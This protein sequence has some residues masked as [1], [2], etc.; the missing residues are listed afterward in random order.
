MLPSVSHLLDDPRGW[1]ERPLEDLVDH[2][3]GHH[4]A[5]RH[6]VP[7]LVAAARA[8]DG[9]D[10]TVP[11]G[12][13]ALLAGLWASMDDHMIQEEALLFPLVRAGRGRGLALQIRALAE[14]H[15]DHLGVYDRLRSVTSDLCPGEAASDACRALYAELVHLEDEIRRHVR[16]EEDVLFPR[17]LTE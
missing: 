13:G 8:V 2:L 9:V 15:A 4:D 16:L 12:L 14:E 17:A 6:L 10:G 11:A 7:R 1:A 5:L 3:V